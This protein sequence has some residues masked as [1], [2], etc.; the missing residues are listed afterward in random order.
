MA[1][2]VYD[3]DEDDMDEYNDLVMKKT[4]LEM[5]LHQLQKYVEDKYLG[6]EELED[7]DCYIDWVSGAIYLW[8]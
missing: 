6:E 2:V 4:Q 5:E 1:E 3:I 8:S 7:G